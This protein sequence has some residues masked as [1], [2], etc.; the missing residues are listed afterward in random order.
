MAIYLIFFINIFDP[1]IAIEDQNK[2]TLAL[3][4][5]A[6]SKKSTDRLDIIEEV[7]NKLTN[8]FSDD[9]NDLSL[10]NEEAK[11]FLRNYLQKI[12]RINV[13]IG[14][15]L[16]LNVSILNSKFLLNF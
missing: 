3:T 16:N 2:E 15:L 5:S 7:L 4:N 11:E 12:E 6:K 14:V 1:I 8:D 13:N 10:R 9:F